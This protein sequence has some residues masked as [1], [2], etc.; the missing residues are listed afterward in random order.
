MLYTIM[1]LEM[2]MNNSIEN[3]KTETVFVNGMMI[4]GVKCGEHMRVTRI[5][6]SNPND[7]LNNGFLL[8]RYVKLQSKVN[9]NV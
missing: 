8:G 3:K 4:E 5:I 6:S 9:K 2:V 7:Y 1:P